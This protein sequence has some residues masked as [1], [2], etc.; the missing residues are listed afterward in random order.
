V[1]SV[2]V[3]AWLWT[4]EGDFTAAYSSG[5]GERLQVALPDG[6]T[7][8]LN[9]QTRIAVRYSDHRRVVKLLE[10]EAFFDVR[11]DAARP[12]VVETGVG[13]VRDVGTRFDV[14]EE[15]GDI[16]VTV[17]DGSVEITP[18]G[19]RPDI[20]PVRLNAGYAARVAEDGSVTVVPADAAAASAWREGKIVF[21]DRTLADVVRQLARY[22]ERPIRL[23]DE[24]V[25]RL[26]V[27][28]VFSVDDTGALL[29]ALPRL[30]PVVVRPL[31]DGSVEIASL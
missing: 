7:V 13:E 9:A 23:A 5:R 18:R 17:Q 20:V 14:L 25:A 27:S 30:L 10:G 8:A 26:R 3:G 2:G 21:E 31:P 6:A 15:G 22:R 19:R 12:F 29:R 16:A 4:G 1:L 28:G 24:R 11:H